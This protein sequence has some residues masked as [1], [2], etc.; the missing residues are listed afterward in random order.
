LYKSYAN[1]SGLKGAEVVAEITSLPS[2]DIVVQETRVTI[3]EIVVDS[4]ALEQAS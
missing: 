4:I 2:G 1:E 3:D